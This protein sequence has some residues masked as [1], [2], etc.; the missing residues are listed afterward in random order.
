MIAS[1]IYR[2]GDF[3]VK[4]LEAMMS[5]WQDLDY[6]SEALPFD[7][8]GYYEE[9][10]GSGLLRRIV[11]FQSLIDPGAL[12]MIKRATNQ[13]E[14]MLSAWSERGRE[15]NIDPGY[16]NAYHLILATTKPAPHRPYLREGILADLTLV[17]QEK[18]FQG[19][20]WTYP[21]YRSEKMIAI[22]H[23]IRQKYLFKRKQF[24]VEPDLSYGSEKL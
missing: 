15:V 20:S 7:Y 24:L 5:Q 18:R 10:M 23:A 16:V 8:T 17:F 12:A 4:A 13:I 1:I 3:L 2:E 19:L 22:F 11:S 6:V 9:E 14:E 21:D